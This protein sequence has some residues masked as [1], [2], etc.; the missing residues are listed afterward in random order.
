[1]TELASPGV[2]LV[3]ARLPFPVGASVRLRLRARDIS[4]T[5]ER[6][7]SLSIQN[8]IEAEIAS[9]RESGPGQI[10]VTL[11]TREGGTRFHAL[12]TQRAARQ[13]SLAEGMPVWALVK[14]VAIAG[15]GALPPPA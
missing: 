3:V 10:D 8:V 9:L 11:R 1:M 13:L 4:I 5:T 15:G 2:P 6:P 12:I 14:T 7:K